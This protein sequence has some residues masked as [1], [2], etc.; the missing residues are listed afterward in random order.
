MRLFYLLLILF[1]AQVG[2]AQKFNSLVNTTPL[3]VSKVNVTE[4]KENQLF[5]AMPFAKKLVLNP[6]QKKQNI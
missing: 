3:L 2:V 1:N 4:L 6:E 5:I